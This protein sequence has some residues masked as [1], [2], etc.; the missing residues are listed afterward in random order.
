MGVWHVSI[1]QIIR[2]ESIT[3]LSHTILVQSPGVFSLPMS[4]KSRRLFTASRSQ[5]VLDIR[6]WQ[7][8]DEILVITGRWFDP[9]FCGAGFIATS[10][11]HMLNGLFTN[12]DIWLVY[13]YLVCIVTDAACGAGKCSL[14]P[15]HIISLPLGSSW[16]HPFIMYTLC[17]VNLSV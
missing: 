5:F 8:R 11:S 12:C 10:V 16:F 9:Y 4:C 3:S 17:I 1:P 7:H 6:W 15:E 13:S 2:P 14:F